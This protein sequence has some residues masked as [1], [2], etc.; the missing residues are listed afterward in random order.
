MPKSNC[1]KL[2][3]HFHILK[4]YFVDFEPDKNFL[5]KT[6]EQK[7]LIKIGLETCK[8]ELETIILNLFKNQE[9]SVAGV[10]VDFLSDVSLGFRIKIFPFGQKRDFQKIRK[11]AFAGNFEIIFPDKKL[12]NTSLRFLIKN[13]RFKITDVEKMLNGTIHIT[14]EPQKS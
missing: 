7:R 3:N 5:Q 11:T 12:L 8:K 4:G 10:A 2:L 9:I 13:K 14:L 1:Q 6:G